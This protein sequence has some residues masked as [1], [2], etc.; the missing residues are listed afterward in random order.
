MGVF[1]TEVKMYKEILPSIMK[2]SE[3]KNKISFPRTYYSNDEEGVLFMDNLRSE[4][5]EMVDKSIGI[6][7]SFSRVSHKQ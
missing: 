5:Y 2:Y 7:F 4:G 3:D 6:L 1:G